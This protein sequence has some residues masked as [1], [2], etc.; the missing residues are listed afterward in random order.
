MLPAALH[1]QQKCRQEKEDFSHVNG[2]VK[3]KQQLYAEFNLAL[4]QLQN[5]AKSRTA[6][7]QKD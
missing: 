4:Q 5:E 7:N 2:F 6:N 3:Y 1:N